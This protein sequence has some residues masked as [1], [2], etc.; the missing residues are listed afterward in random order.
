MDEEEE[1]R[2]INQ[3]TEDLT[4]AVLSE[5]IV[6]GIS[7]KQQQSA[8]AAIAAIGEAAKSLI[9]TCSPGIFASALLTYGEAMTSTFEGIAQDAQPEPG[10]R[11]VFEHIEERIATKTGDDEDEDE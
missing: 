5:G 9:G 1:K 2:A 3:F 6:I 11:Q 7:E 4:N 10:G 8:R